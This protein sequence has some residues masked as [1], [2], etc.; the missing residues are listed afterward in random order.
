MRACVRVCMCVCMRACEQL[1]YMNLYNNCTCISV[2]PPPPSP[3]VP[4]QVTLMNKD[5]QSYL[6]IFDG[7]LLV[8]KLLK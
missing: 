2:P 3:P 6:V 7:S 5:N 8:S 1:R 4:A